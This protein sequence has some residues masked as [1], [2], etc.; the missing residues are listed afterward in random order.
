MGKSR[1]KAF[2]ISV[3]AVLMVAAGLPGAGFAAAPAL[4]LAVPAADWRPLSQRGD[5]GLQ[6]RLEQALQKNKAWQS[7]VNE[8][9][10][11][12]GL[13]NL[14][15]PKAP[16]F[17][18]VNGATT[19]YA[20]SLPKIAVLLA[21]FQGFED[22]TLQ[23]T[24]EIHRDLI[25]MIRRSSNHAATRMIAR[26]GLK[27]IQALLN[28]PRYRFYDPAT[29]G[30][31]WVGGTYSYGGPEIPE[32]ITGALQTA[33]VNQVCRFYY[34]L[35]YGRLISPERSRQMLKILS[36]PDL[37]DKFVV[38]LKG[39]VPLNQ[40][41]RKSGDWRGCYS[42]SMLVWG[43]AGHRYI[44]VALVENPRGEQILRE[45]VP[46]AAGVLRPGA[47]SRPVRAGEKSRP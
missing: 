35:A 47:P 39:S 44:L 22:G 6:A 12:V 8:K 7:L 27:K 31:L 40:V 29:G 20:A 25:D 9:K 4:P 32:P 37:P 42:D 46:V 38:G 11:A 30:G 16:R 2:S 33:S 14:A 13:V 23:E 3:V 15:D 5:K 19:M 18:Q 34:L 26:I 41:Y 36:F 43:E 21:A 17:A 1:V 28:D 24:A 45:L 10:M